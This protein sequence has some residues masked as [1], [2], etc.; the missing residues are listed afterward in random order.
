[1][2]TAIRDNH[3]VLIICTPHYA[4]RSN[5][6]IGGAGYEG[7]IMTAEVYTQRNHQKFIP[8]LRSGDWR[9]GA[10]TWL[11]GKY[12]VDLR[13][14]PFS[15]E[16]YTDLLNTL[17]GTRPKAPPVQPRRSVV[18]TSSTPQV[19]QTEPPHFQPIRILNIV[20]D[21]VTAPRNDGTRGSALY[22]VPFQLSRRPSSEW[23]DGFVHN[24]DH[25][26]QWDTSHR[27]GIARVSGDKIYLDGTTIEEVRD[28]HRQTLMLA[29]DATNRIIEDYERRKFAKEREQ[30]RVKEEHERRV[31]EGANRIKFD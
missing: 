12:G 24:W 2:E 1:M 11:S 17:H 19:S 8:V 16:Q 18:A 29:L 15:E 20:V 14:D 21:E 28:T 23:A 4:D 3:F 13:S 10:P 7:D 30:R 26:P 6:R 27:P 22:C 25:P 5:R 31:R 9:T